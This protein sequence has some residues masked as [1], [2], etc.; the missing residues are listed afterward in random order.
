MRA[1]PLAPLPLL[2]RGPVHPWLH[3][4]AEGVVVGRLTDAGEVQLV[5]S[6]RETWNPA[7][8][9]AALAFAPRPYADL[10]GRWPD[11][12]VEAWLL[13][14][15]TPTFA[16]VLALLMHTLERVMEFPRPAHRALLATWALGTYF[17]PAFL[18][19]PRLSLSGERGCGKSKALG[20]LR[21]TAWHGLLMLS[22][23]PAVL[24]RLVHEF[25]ATLLL[26]EVEGLAREDAREVVAIVNAGYKAGA[27]VPRCEGKDQKR[28]EPFSVYAPLA[29]AAIRAPNPTTEDRCI[30]V[31]MQRG[32]DPSRVNAEVDPAAP[33]FGRIRAGCYRLLLT[34]W[35]EVQA[36]SRT[37]PLPEWLQ[38]RARELWKP[39]LAVASL[40]DQDGLDVTPDLLSLAREHVEDRVE[41]SAEGEALLAE[42]ADQLG[43]LASITVRPGELAEPLRRRLGWRDAP[44]AA[45]VGAW[46]RRFGFRRR[47]KDR[48]GAR[49]EVTA[50]HLREVTGRFTPG[51][52]RHTVTVTG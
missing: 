30:P 12:D 15:E 27:T 31:V 24:F 48:E 41:V 25:R 16:E 29:L 39:L 51:G 46:L 13:G 45:Q 21:E 37:V 3:A 1:L 9:K 40:A 32:T 19:F 36:A 22:P 6:A 52:D 42:L 49:Y 33:L 5:T 35:R 50:D 34:R 11:A 26:D 2:G 10:A 18:A 44:T 47:G 4:D 14:A 7:E 43:T 23:T 20:V 38:A 17:H 28:V 8:A